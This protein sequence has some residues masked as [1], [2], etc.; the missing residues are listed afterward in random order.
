MFTP[1]TKIFNSSLSFF[2]RPVLHGEN[3]FKQS[4]HIFIECAGAP[5][6]TCERHSHPTIQP[7]EYSQMPNPPPPAPM[8]SST[9]EHLAIYSVNF[10]KVLNMITRPY[11]FA[12]NTTINTCDFPF[13]PFLFWPGYHVKFPLNT[14][15]SVLKKIKN[16]I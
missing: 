16:L 11:F 3:S 14:S 13:S 1:A 6:I 8:F 12:Q 7:K 9:Y 2:E 5:L 10:I 4:S 15:I